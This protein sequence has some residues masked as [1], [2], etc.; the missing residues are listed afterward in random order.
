MPYFT[1]NR[2]IRLAGTLAVAACAA[3]S[4]TTSALAADGV[5]ANT[6]AASNAE[7]VAP[8][9]F[10][11]FTS[12]RDSRHYVLAPGGDFSNPGGGGW[13]FDGGAKIVTEANA[14]GSTDGVLAMPTG[15]TAVS[16]TMCVDLNYPTA[17]TWVRNAAGDGDVTVSVVYDAGKS[18]Q[19]PHAVGKLSGLKQ[20]TWGLSADIK[21]QPQLAGKQAGW[22]RV[23]FVLEAGGKSSQFRID[24]FY[25]DPRMVR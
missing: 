23:A 19:T 13:K 8:S 14:N 9:L 25:V 17:R 10:Q 21:I 4:A 2:R 18:A 22:R 16:P 3:L 1:W 6:T 24:D 7:C 20:A 5:T 15:S 11:P 12:F